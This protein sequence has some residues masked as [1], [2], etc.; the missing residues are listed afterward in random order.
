MSIFRASNTISESAARVLAIRARK[1]KITIGGVETRATFFTNQSGFVARRTHKTSI[2]HLI[3][4][5][6][7]NA[8]QI[9]R[10]TTTCF[11]N[12]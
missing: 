8:S 12:A 7:T 4:T 2:R 10:I 5:R 6:N 11:T 9:E 1:T 3:I